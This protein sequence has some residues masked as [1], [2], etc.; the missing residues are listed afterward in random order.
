MPT[1]PV[2]DTMRAPCRPFKPSLTLPKTDYIKYL[3][4]ILLLEPNQPLLPASN[5]SC[6]QRL[7]QQ[8]H[9]F[10]FRTLLP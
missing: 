8:S 7:K 6:V 4:N 9:T 1:E 3:G 10:F 5:V 2:A